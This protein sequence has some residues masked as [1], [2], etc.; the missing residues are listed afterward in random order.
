MKL[1]R[2]LLLSLVSLLA[3]GSGA[4]SAAIG[5]S[6]AAPSVS[7]DFNSMWNAE[8]SAA[9]LALPAD[10]RV[11]RN[12]SAPRRVN[13]WS[14]CA[15]EVMYQGGVSLASN[16]KNGTW[17][18]G[19]DDS[20]RAIGGL[21]TTVDGGTRGLSL[22]THISNTDPEQIITSLSL[23]Y[24]IE[25]YR[26]G[27]NPAGFAVQLFSSFDGSKWTAAGD[28]FITFFP[29][30]D[31][32]A[33]AAIVPISS[34]SV[35]DKA[36]R[37]HVEPGSDLYLAWN[38]SVASGTTANKAQGLALD[39]IVIT[40]TFAAEDPEWTTPEEPVKNP[41]GIYI[42][43]EVNGWATDEEWEFSKLSDT[44]FEL[45]GMT[46][47]GQFKIG[48]ATW[49]DAC[50]YGSNGSNILMDEPYALVAG[51][52]STNISCG[53]NSYYCSRILLSISDGGE[54]TLLLEPDNDATGLTSVYM[55]GDFNSWNF[56]DPSGKL[57]L[58]AA[59]GLFKGRV[60]MTPAADGL[61]HWR[62]Y[63]RLGMGGAWGLEADAV[64]SSLSGTL[65]QGMKH[66]AALAGGTYDVVFDLATGQY[67]FTKVSSV[68]TSMTLSPAS[69]VL[70]PAMP[71][72]VRVLSLNNSLIHY[73]D[74]A[75]MFNDIAKAMGADAVW[76]KHTLLGKSLATHWEEGDGLAA[77]GMPGAKMLV[78][79]QPWTHII[80]QEQS[81]LPRTSPDTFRANVERWVSYI[82][83]NCPNP[84]AVIILPVNWAY[85]GDW[86]NFSAFN[87]V[88]LANYRQVAS[89][90]GLVI[91]PVMSAY[92]TMFDQSG[93]EGLAPWF[94]DDRHPTDLSTYMAACMEYG[95]IMGVDP[96]E[97][98]TQPTA[99]PATDAADMRARAAA[100]LKAY[101]QTVD[102]AAAT[103]RFST[104]LLDEF[105]MPLDH[106]PSF[107]V[108]PAE[109]ASITPDGVFTA[110][111][112]GLYTV[113]ATAE[114]FN[115]SSSVLVA[116]HNTEVVAL[117][118]I[119]LS[120]DAPNYSQ[121][122]NTIGTE[123][124]AALPAG[125]RIART[126]TPREVGSFRGAVENTMYAGGINLPSNAKN[127]LW[128]FGPDDSD[129]AVGGI[130][131]GVA[132]GTRS[133]SIYARFVNDGRKSLENIAISY[134]IEK[135][136]DGNN[137]AGFAVTLYT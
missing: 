21:T 63:Q 68:P 123:A 37:T 108:S 58:D 48:D 51:G 102:H 57:D 60:S 28:E 120:A 129:R 80:L 4:A 9:T 54:A 105:G 128:N 104:T 76:T 22:L 136:R 94:Q 50:N 59:D 110:T 33:G 34:L 85:A 66:N 97:I 20:D 11:D 25:K 107:T 65:I 7:E 95:L 36:L 52:T 43:G 6:K 12:L 69:A 121:N 26:K 38:I 117:P 111:A 73:N 27:D 116:E 131:T 44:S 61:C 98:S 79:S 42:R 114:G 135:Y 17:N 72:A 46:L 62:L 3:L 91:C 119:S 78:R 99:V 56:M 55:V 13:P 64:E 30:D 70:T 134:D 93:A 10:W 32:T 115:T 89:E 109:G 81:S 75:L 82:R 19:A 137:A 113:S 67:S 8:T 1:S 47:S 24:N 100:A 87:E 126:Y 23:S 86:T 88:F 92:Q 39:D 133:V 53:P 15:S 71:E 124:T 29:A 103:I 112:P 16:A 5:L 41:S 125:W 118:S 18:F 90:F 84:N 130:T 31:A 2:K 77:D 132:D 14:E 35:K 49:S 96:T 101:V 106:V 45:R 40:A 122:F 83:E 127:G 74:Q